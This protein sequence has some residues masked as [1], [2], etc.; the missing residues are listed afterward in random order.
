[1]IILS[2]K[3]SSPEDIGPRYVADFEEVND[4]EQRLFIQRDAYERMTYLIE[5]IQHLLE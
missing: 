2:T 1:V 5:R 4:S 3:F